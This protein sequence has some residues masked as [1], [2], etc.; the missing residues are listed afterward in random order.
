MPK[1][2]LWIS[3]NVGGLELCEPAATLLLQ[4]Q[5]A[6]QLPRAFTCWAL[7]QGGQNIPCAQLA[8][9]SCIRRAL[10]KWVDTAEDGKHALLHARCEARAGRLA[11]A[12]KAL[13]KATT[14]AMEV[15]WRITCVRMG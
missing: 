10:R 3:L 14:A 7:M 12:L 2:L 1:T 11:A 8:T 4:Q 9:S 15:K 5:G 6:Q 13:D